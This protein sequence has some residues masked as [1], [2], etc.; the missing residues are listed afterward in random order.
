MRDPQ[1]IKKP[2]ALEAFLNDWPEENGSGGLNR[3][4]AATWIGWRSAMRVLPVFWDWVVKSE[5]AAKHEVTVL[6]LLRCLLI[7][8]V[9]AKL[10]PKPRL[11]AYAASASDAVAASRVA[12]SQDIGDHT[13]ASVSAAAARSAVDSV[14]D[15]SE[16]AAAH[17]GAHAVS[18]ANEAMRRSVYAGLYNDLARIFSNEAVHLEVGV[19][20]SKR[21][22]WW[23][24]A[25]PYSDLWVS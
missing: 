18:V 11:V 8:E 19:V 13:A 12:A 5:Y 14:A 9:A 25:N 20:I 21:N 15:S 2:K 1:Q 23:D 17:Y 24:Q 4:Q 22:L 6:P 3:Q 10:K 16:G 7:S